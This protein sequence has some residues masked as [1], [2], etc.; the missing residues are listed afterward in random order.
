MMKNNRVFNSILYVCDQT[1]YTKAHIMPYKFVYT[2]VQI[3]IRIY[4]HT[5]TYINFHL[6]TIIHIFTSISEYN[7]TYT[8]IYDTTLL[9]HKKTFV[10]LFTQKYYQGYIPFSDMMSVWN[11][12]PSNVSGVGGLHI[13]THDI[14]VNLNFTRHWYVNLLL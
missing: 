4:I 12:F 8:T 11:P 6:I 7:H 1:H 13:M 9:L 3:Y 5:L 14:A 2:P 10:T